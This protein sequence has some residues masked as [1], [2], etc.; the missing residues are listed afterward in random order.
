MTTVD[1]LLATARASLNRL[2]PEEAHH[3]AVAGDSI[4]GRRIAIPR[5]RT[6]AGG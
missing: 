6:R 4:H 2:T 5:L 1:E 3:A